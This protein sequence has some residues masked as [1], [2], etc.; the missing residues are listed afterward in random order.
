MGKHLL[1]NFLVPLYTHF[2]GRDK[3]QLQEAIITI[4]YAVGLE[5]GYLRKKKARA[6]ASGW[7]VTSVS[8]I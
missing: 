7:Y 2:G 5:S 1:V 8:R 4:S 3:A 6:N